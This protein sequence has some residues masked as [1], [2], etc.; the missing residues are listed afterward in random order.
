MIKCIFVGC[1]RN[2][3][4]ALLWRQSPLQNL[5]KFV[6]GAVNFHRTMVYMQPRTLLNS[7]SDVFTKVFWNM[8][9]R[10]LGRITYVVEFPFNEIARLQ[11][12]TYCRTKNSTADTGT[13]PARKRCYNIRKFQKNLWKSVPFLL[14]HQACRLQLTST[15]TE[16]PRKTF[17][18]SF[19]KNLHTGQ[20]KLCNEVTLL[21]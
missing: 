21:K 12:T 11:S 9:T 10:H 14:T 19:L 17:P 3:L 13:Y 7:V 2:P 16:T 20:E 18:P 5:R 8:C 6:Y 1:Y 4:Q 15:K